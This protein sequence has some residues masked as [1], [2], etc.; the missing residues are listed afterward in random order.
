M[1][2]NVITIGIGLMKVASLK[3]F[4]FL[5][6]NLNFNNVL[7]MILIIMV[8]FYWATSNVL[9]TV[10]NILNTSFHLILSIM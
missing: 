7:P 9:D 8:I 5:I 6:P 10:Q 2:Y 3:E 4:I 1:N